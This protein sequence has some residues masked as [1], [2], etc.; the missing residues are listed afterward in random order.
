MIENSI[1]KK[2]NYLT[3]LS[4]SNKVGKHNEKYF[5]C[6][7]DCGHIW[8]VRYDL[9]KYSKINSCGCKSLEDLTGQS[10]HNLTV[11]KDSG[12][13]TRTR[14]HNGERYWECLCKCGNTTLV[15]T[16]GVKFKKVKSC[17]CL[18]RMVG[19][20][21]HSWKGYEEI[22]GD[23]HRNLLVNASCR[24]FSFDVTLEYLWNLYVRQNRKCALS[25]VEIGFGYG[26]SNRERRKTKTASLDRIDSLLGYTIGNLQWIHKDLNPMK[27]NLSDENFIEWCCLVAAYRKKY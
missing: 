27:R 5:D 14:F 6:R 24:G 13:R 18:N 25:G 7:C 3:V 17:G 10:F 4:I 8:P 9:L 23:Y 2:I 11:I 1:G 15:T 16:S 12:Q 20:Q 26:D 22:S 21:H 19:K